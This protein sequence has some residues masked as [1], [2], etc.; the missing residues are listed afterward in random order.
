VPEQL[1]SE[2]R[3]FVRGQ[4]RR[5]ARAMGAQ[6]KPARLLDLLFDVQERIQ[7]HM[8]VAHAA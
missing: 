7:Q 8:E 4:S 3:V 1:I 5:L 2:I 6:P